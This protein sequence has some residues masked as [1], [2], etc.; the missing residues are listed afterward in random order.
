MVTTTPTVPAAGLEENRGGESAVGVSLS[1][2]TFCK[3]PGSYV[4]DTVTVRGQPP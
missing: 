2:V 3:D 1:V 4:R